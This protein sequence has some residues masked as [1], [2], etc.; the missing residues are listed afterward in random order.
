MIKN[1][2]NFII[3][4]IL[5]C[6]VVLGLVLRAHD[7][8][9]WPREGA[10]FDEQAWTFLGL[11]IIKGGIPISWS[12]HMAYT[13]TIDY[14]HPHG[15]HY[16]LV[17]PYIEHPPLFGLIAG[18]FA[19]VRGIR[20]FDAVTIHSIRPLALIMGGLSIVFLY[21]FTRVLYG[22]NIALVTSLCYSIIPSVV[23]GSRL[24][25][26]ENFFI[27]MYLIALYLTSLYL[28]KMRISVLIVLLLITLIMPLAKIPWAAGSVAVAAIFL[29]YKK[30]Q[31]T[32]FVLLAGLT[33]I[34][35]YSIYA[36]ILD[37]TLFLQL[38]SLQLARY[39]MT[40]DSFLAILTTPLI[41]DRLY[42]DGWIY[43]GWLAMAV[44]VFSD[45]KKNAV[46]I[47]SFLAYLGVYLIAIPNE[48]GHGWYRYP[49]YP[50]L[51][52]AIGIYLVQFMKKQNIYQ[53]VFLII[54]GLS[55]L[56]HA[57]VPVFGFSYVLYRLYVTLSAVPLIS[58]VFPSKSV[59]KP[60]MILNSL[61]I[62]FVFIMTVSATMQ[63]NEQ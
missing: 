11:S 31:E 19:Y 29:Y 61:L 27:L 55:M 51:A 35:I 40:F 4:F 46:V 10:T 58:V 48:P 12:P 62:I 57:W 56:E 37:K 18:G 25:Q 13:Q 30:Y 42:T 44:A 54:V 50:F 23:I 49:F 45:F 38:M 7:L 47:I 21:L 20:S 34:A 6:I 60:A 17:Q 36:M 32:V 28:K 63:Y 22:T 16:R 52:I 43:F 1:S 5:V 53:F 15:T 3:L 24:V 59:T 26:N 41:T 8:T 9:T 39:D 2:S 14:I 33:G